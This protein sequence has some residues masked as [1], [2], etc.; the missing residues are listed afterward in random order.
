MKFLVRFSQSHES[1]RKAELEALAEVNGIDLQ[2]LDYRAD[3]GESL[4]QHA[5]PGQR[6][7]IPQA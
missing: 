6:L 4:N 2:V 7:H 1:F 5:T 3:V